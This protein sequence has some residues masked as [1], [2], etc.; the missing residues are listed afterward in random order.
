[1]NTKLNPNEPWVC[2][3]YGRCYKDADPTSTPECSC[4]TEMYTGPRCEFNI[5]DPKDVAWSECNL[6]CSNDGICL[7]GA[8]KPIAEIFIPFIEGTKKS[9]LFDYETPEF[10]YC[11]CPD[12]FF[13]V[14]CDKQYDICGRRD[15]I[16]FHGSKCKNDGGEWGC[17]CEGT[18]SAGLYCQYK[19]TDDCGDG[20]LE[21]FCT[22]KATCTLDS[23]SNAVCACSEGWEGSKCETEV[24]LASTSGGGDEWS[25]ASVAGRLV[26]MLSIA[27]LSIALVIV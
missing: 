16:C 23:S 22:N 10:E 7:K 26:S 8:V 25:S 21:L 18:E 27:V 3:G 6:Q 20:D 13:G 12:G 5:T 24:K 1:M 17:D 4:G 14:Q 15:H 19:A 9:G 2:A 11:Y